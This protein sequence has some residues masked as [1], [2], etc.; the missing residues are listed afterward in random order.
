MLSSEIDLTDDQKVSQPPFMFLS[1]QS[2]VSDS[3][4]TIRSPGHDIASVS[5]HSTLPAQYLGLASHPT[6]IDST[7]QALD[8]RQINPLDHEQPLRPGSD[9]GGYT[10][11]MAFRDGTNPINI[12]TDALGSAASE[13]LA[14]NGPATG[15]SWMPTQAT[16]TSPTDVDTEF[17]RKKGAFSLPPRHVWYA[18]L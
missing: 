12:L 17:L 8:D 4:S 7:D 1:H 14:S 16:P 9:S 2:P 11:A 10:D 5:D 13:R 15:G 18:T 6:H 3:N